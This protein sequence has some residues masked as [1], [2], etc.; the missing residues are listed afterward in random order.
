MNCRS[1]LPPLSDT[2]RYVRYHEYGVQHSD[3]NETWRDADE[4]RPDDGKPLRPADMRVEAGRAG[5]ARVQV[6][7]VVDGMNRLARQLEEAGVKMRAF[8]NAM[9][10]QV[11]SMFPTQTRRDIDRRM[12]TD[13]TR[14]IVPRNVSIERHL[15]PKE[16]PY[17]MGDFERGFMPRMEVQTETTIEIEGALA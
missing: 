2:P 4:G 6:R 8:V 3:D 10:K 11:H 16:L 9:P 12:A 14:R 13:H 7:L 15:V 1:A 17:R 5:E